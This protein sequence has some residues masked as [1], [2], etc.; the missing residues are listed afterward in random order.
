MTTPTPPSINWNELR[1]QVAAAQLLEAR[2]MA[3]L[4]GGMGLRTIEE[5]TLDM[6][7]LSELRARIQATLWY[8]ILQK[9]PT[10]PQKAPPQTL[11]N[12]DRERGSQT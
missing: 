10:D 9:P 6:G 1:A 12:R 4:Q 3:R 8:A 5:T 11:Y 2:I 7:H